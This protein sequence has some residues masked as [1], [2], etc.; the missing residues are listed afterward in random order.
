MGLY[1]C[2]TQARRPKVANNYIE[3][4]TD[5]K[6]D[7]SGMYAV[8]CEAWSRCRRWSSGS[9]RRTQTTCRT[10]SKSPPS[11]DRQT[12]PSA[13]A[14]RRSRLLLRP[15]AADQVPGE[16]HHVRRKRGPQG[17][18]E[19]RQQRP[20]SRSL[21]TMKTDV[22]RRRRKIQESRGHV[23]RRCFHYALFAARRQKS[24]L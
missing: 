7:T 24:Q 14:P 23:A 17:D 3:L 1:S 8:L 16:V 12:S 15:A 20:P 9:G 22:V 19:A 2:T 18:Q 11:G 6:K 13:A 4:A 10:L 21:C 5:S